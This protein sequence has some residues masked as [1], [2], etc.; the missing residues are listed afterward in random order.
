MWS[1]LRDPIHITM[2][3]NLAWHQPCA[4]DDFHIHADVL[5]L[6]E[7]TGRCHDIYHDSL[8]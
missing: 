2:L 7:L 5:H 4:A 8:M 1:I 3:P 6:Y